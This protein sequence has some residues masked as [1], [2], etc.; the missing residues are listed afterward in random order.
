M[1][2]MPRMRTIVGVTNG[3]V[4][5]GGW[6]GGRRRVVIDWVLFHDSGG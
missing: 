4:S 6:G 1:D 3:V 5:G 2:I